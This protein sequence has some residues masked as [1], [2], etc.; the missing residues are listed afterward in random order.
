MNKQPRYKRVKL[1]V[2]SYLD[3]GSFSFVQAMQE[4][5]S[6]AVV[7]RLKWSLLTLWGYNHK[8]PF[9]LTA[10]GHHFIHD[11]FS[12]WVQILCYCKGGFFLA[13][14]TP[15][16]PKLLAYLLLFVNL[17]VTFCGTRF[18]LEI[19]P[20]CVKNKMPT[21]HPCKPV[22]LHHM[23][24]KDVTAGLFYVNKKC[25]MIWL[26]FKIILLNGGTV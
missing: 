17:D 6:Y 20:Q 26:R 9:H 12:L 3:T 2:I 13:Q 8:I 23:S 16:F 25:F 21:S 22:F 11:D 18:F 1:T 7:T 4:I 10:L 24:W 15:G 14:L 19:V 5:L